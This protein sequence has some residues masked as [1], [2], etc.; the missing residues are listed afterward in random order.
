MTSCLLF[1]TPCIPFCSGFTLKGKGKEFTPNKEGCVCVCVCGGGG[2]GFKL[3]PFRVDPF[4]E[5]R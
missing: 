2:G 3:L 1:C 5:G 4:S